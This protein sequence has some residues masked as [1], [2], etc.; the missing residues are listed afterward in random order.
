MQDIIV[1]QSDTENSGKSKKVN[2]KKVGNKKVI[3]GLVAVL[4]LV[5]LLGTFYYY[6]KYNDVKNNPTAAQ[7]DKNKAETQRVLDQVKAMLFISETDAPTVARVEDPSKLKEANKEFYKDIQKGDY[8]IIY[9][10]RAI[11]Y[12][13]SNH[14]IMNIAPIIN[15]ADLKK[16][17][18]QTQ[19]STQ[20]AATTN[21][22]NN[23]IR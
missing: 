17:Q 10:K 3:Y 5:G 2:L 1:K 15:T 22:T 19:G 16:T 4:V 11:I 21:N 12:R 18:D 8:L 20:P 23:T 6:K 13:E 14:Q 9:P 7:D